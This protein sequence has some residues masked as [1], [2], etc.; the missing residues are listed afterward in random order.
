MMGG[1][2]VVRDGGGEQML[3]NGLSRYC[4]CLALRESAVN[5]RRIG[6]GE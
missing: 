1:A 4:L 3:P 2:G 5:A 6:R